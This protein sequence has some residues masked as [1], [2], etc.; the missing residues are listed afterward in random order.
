MLLGLPRLNR[1]EDEMIDYLFDYLYPHPR[2]PFRKKLVSFLVLGLLSCG[3]LYL[4]F[5]P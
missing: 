4:L 1:E 3:L 5:H 2:A